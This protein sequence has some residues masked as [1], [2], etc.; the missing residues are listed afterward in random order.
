MNC[1][2]VLDCEKKEEQTQI[3]KRSVLCKSLF[4]IEY[5]QNF[6]RVSNNTTVHAM[7]IGCCSVGVFGLL[8][9][10]DKGNYSR[11]VP[12]D[13]R[14]MNTYVL[15]PIL[16]M[17][18]NNATV[19]ATKSLGSS[20]LD[21]WEYD[22]ECGIYER[23]HF[24]QINLASNELSNRLKIL[25]FENV[26][27][28]RVIKCNVK[29]NSYHTWSRQLYHG[30]LLNKDRERY[31][32][33]TMA[34]E[35]KHFDSNCMTL[36]RFV[37]AEQ[38]KHPGATGDLT[39][40]LNAIQTAVKVISCA[41]RKAGITQ[42]FGTVGEQNVQGEEVKKLDVLANE[43]FINMIKSSFTTC[44]MVSEE[45]D[46]M[47][48]VEVEKSGKYIVTFD[49]LDGS[50]NID[51]LVSIGS[52]FAI[53]RKTGTGPPTLQDA[54]QPGNN[55]VA[56]GYALYGSATMMVLSIGD[57]VNGFML[58]PS[59]GEF[60]LSDKDMRIPTRGK[61]YS[62]NE[63][64]AY[65]WDPAIREY[66]HSKKDPK[67][68]KPYG[69]RYVGSMVADV[70]RTIK[71][72]G[73]FLYPATTSTP[74]GKLRLLYEGIPMAHI[75]TKAGGIA[76]NGHIPILDVVPENIHQRSPI[77]LGSKDDVEDVLALIKH[78]SK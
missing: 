56:A 37:L 54:L 25:E 41:V 12:D 47:I 64:Y 73:I 75:I 70:H 10:N 51:C 72:G 74:K 40:L 77:F 58:D 3:T 19:P 13:L 38:K 5:E 18:S 59:I 62:I 65:E 50:S 21:F 69:A 11:T 28:I 7:I 76:S 61:I 23:K 17:I 49:P 63:G 30:P 67:N 9:V 42:L 43:L 34:S 6:F 57:S 16:F 22:Y 1:S 8:L 35:G 24:I 27:T 14:Y 78:H 15:A 39:Q 71:Y 32:A 45:N 48:E 44:A 4:I 52:I 33:S 66:V 29:N 53:F 31:K 26:V 68:G 36:T 2:R 46:Q 60:I 20:N 55:V